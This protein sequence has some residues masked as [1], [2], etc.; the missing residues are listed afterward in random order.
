[1]ETIRERILFLLEEKEITKTEFA[2]KLNITQA[3]VSKITNKGA[4]PSD[5]LIEDI[6]EKFNV[7]EEWLRTGKGEKFVALNRTQQIA[8]LTTDLFK[9]E[10]DSFKE[11]L[12][13]ALS[14]LDESDWKVLE[15][16]ANDLIKE[17]D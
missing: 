7:N 11:R 3:Y 14:K 15:R 10:K 16:I 1:M 6:C 5:R 9:G 13:F 12:L 8:K 2:S 17:K 4:I